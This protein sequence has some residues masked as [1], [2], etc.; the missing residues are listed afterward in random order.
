M[1]TGWITTNL[2]HAAQAQPTWKRTEVIENRTFKCWKITM[3]WKFLKTEADHAYNAEYSTKHQNWTIKSKNKAPRSLPN[4]EILSLVLN[5]SRILFLFRQIFL[6]CCAI[7]N[8]VFYS[9]KI[10]PWDSNRPF[11][12]VTLKYLTMKKVKTL[13]ENS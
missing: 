6:R 4:W 1:L 8:I 5:T 2:K 7:N 10:N 3:G 11:T 13:N 12:G 9:W